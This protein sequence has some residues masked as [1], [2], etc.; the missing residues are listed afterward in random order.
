VR[1]CG[2]SGLCNIFQLHDQGKSS[3]D[4]SEYNN[5]TIGTSHI[6]GGR[7]CTTLLSGRGRGCRSASKPVVNLSRC[8]AR[9]GARCCCCD[10][11]T[12]GCG[13]RSNRIL[14][15]ARMISSTRRL[16]RSVSIAASHTLIAVL[17]ADEVWEGF[18]EFRGV[19]R[20]SV[21]A[22]AGKC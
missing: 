8:T 22:D 7:L 10:H 11:G 2:Y 21:S 4:T 18:G 14:S 3:K 19:G 5:E 9:S 16:A 1:C 20:D 15:S 13:V 17:L 12:R 6:Q